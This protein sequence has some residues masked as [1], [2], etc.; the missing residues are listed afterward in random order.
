MTILLGGDN[1]ARYSVNE[2]CH[3]D[4]NRNFMKIVAGETI[5]RDKIG[6]ITVISNL[7]RPLQA[8]HLNFFSSILLYITNLQ[9]STYA[10]KSTTL[11]LVE[12]KSRMSLSRRGAMPYLS[13]NG[14]L[15]FVL[16]LRPF[17]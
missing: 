1:F 15:I 9:K 3:G 5:I 10:S 6:S 12:S 8:L 11:I 14:L 17:M 13:K 16:A 7:V 4:K 2:P